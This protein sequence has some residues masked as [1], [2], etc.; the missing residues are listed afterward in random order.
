M[1]FKDKLS[2]TVYF[3][4]DLVCLLSNNTLEGPTGIFFCIILAILILS[5]L[6]DLPAVLC[7]VSFYAGSGPVTF[8]S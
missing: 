1:I 4:K 5:K 6:R 8:S 2:S 7:Q 3:I